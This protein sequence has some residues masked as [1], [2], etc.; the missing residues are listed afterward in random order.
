MGYQ[1]GHFAVAASIVYTLNYL[2]GLSRAQ[3]DR[4][5]TDALNNTV[6]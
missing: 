4:T 2:L 3:T 5:L 1:L 6:L